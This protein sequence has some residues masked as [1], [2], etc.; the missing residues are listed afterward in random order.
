MPAT[1]NT[2]KLW[3]FPAGHLVKSL[4]GH[5]S[6]VRGAVFSPDG[7]YVLSGSLDA[8][9]KLWS[10][11]GYEEVRKFQ[12]RVINSPAAPGRGGGRRREAS[13]L[14]AR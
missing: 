8:E 6:W 13:V 2:I 7:D 10:I 12:D 5:A 14:A 3:D 1:T 9:V 4:R 11:A